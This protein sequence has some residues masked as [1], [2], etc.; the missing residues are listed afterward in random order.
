MVVG[1]MK[2]RYLGGTESLCLNHNEIYEAIGRYKEYIAV[3]DNEKEDYMYHSRFFEFLDGTIEDLPTEWERID[4][5]GEGT[6][7]PDFIIEEDTEIFTGRDY[8]GENEDDNEI[9]W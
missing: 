5:Y 1:L 2:V 6:P 8:A 9:E 4:K 7:Q 3:I